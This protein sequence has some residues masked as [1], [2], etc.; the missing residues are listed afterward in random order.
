MGQLAKETLKCR[1]EKKVA[2]TPGPTT[3]ATP[4]VLTVTGDIPTLTKEAL[5]T[6]PVRIIILDLDILFT[7]PKGAATIVTR[8]ITLATATLP[9]ARK[10]K[11]FMAIQ[12]FENPSSNM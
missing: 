1:E 4:T 5:E 6:P 11:D 2:Q 10:N 12:L 8:T 9:A 3:K 7:H